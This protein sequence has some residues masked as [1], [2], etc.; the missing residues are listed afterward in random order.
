ME[1]NLF[2]FQMGRSVISPSPCQFLMSDV[3]GG[4]VG[5]DCYRQ[6][7]CFCTPQVAEH[8]RRW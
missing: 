1:R 4:N 7:S 6:S 5:C 2:N 8:N 3:T